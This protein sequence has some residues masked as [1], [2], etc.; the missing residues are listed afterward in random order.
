MAQ[1]PLDYPLLDLDALPVPAGDPFPIQAPDPLPHP[2]TEK[3]SPQRSAPYY[4]PLTVPVPLSA[5]PVMSNGTEEQ[6][7]EDSSLDL[8]SDLGRIMDLSLAE[9]R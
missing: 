9:Q 1:G 7:M 5:L 4:I 8:S 6:Q 2:P 3:S